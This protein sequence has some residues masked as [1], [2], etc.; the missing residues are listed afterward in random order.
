MGAESSISQNFVWGHTKHSLTGCLNISTQVSM[1]EFLK[2]KDSRESFLMT[3]NEFYKCT[4]P[5]RKI[6][7]SCSIR[8]EL[9]Q[10]QCE[11]K[12]S[13]VVFHKE[14]LCIDWFCFSER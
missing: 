4:L 9:N 1:Q 3:L 11:C 7:M 12:K 10:T 13:I 5:V 8:Q 14:L 6:Q 2:Y